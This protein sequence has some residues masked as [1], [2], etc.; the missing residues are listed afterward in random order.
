VTIRRRVALVLAVAAGALALPA[1]AWAHAALLRTVPLP[2]AVLNSPPPVVL[3]TYSE[4]VEPRFAIV[5]VTNAAGRQETAGPPRRSASDADTLVIPLRRLDHGWYLVYWRVIS[6]DGHPVRSAF[7]FAVG[8]NP[9][10]LPQFPVPSTSETAATPSLV[11]ARAIAFVSVMAAI[12]LFILRMAIARPVVRRVSDTRLRAVS[13]AFGV[14]AAI[15]LLA[16]PVYVVMAT[17]QF[18]LRSS[19]DLGNVLPLVRDSAFGRGYLDL[20]LTFALFV[21][22]G[23]I[24]LR[25]DRPERERRSIAELLSL[26]S[27]FLAAGATLLIPGLAG[28]AV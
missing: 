6:V 1:V 19:F 7:T 17:A 15:A 25:V 9:G 24:A 18:A 8:P 10:P 11:T 12:G 26:G 5:S 27:A 4:A 21:V 20:E 22:A 13:I 28:Y 3:L 2:S 14:A 16:T 23:T